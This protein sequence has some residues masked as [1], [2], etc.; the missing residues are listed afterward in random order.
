MNKVYRHRPAANDEYLGW[1][2]EEG[3][4]YETRLGPDKYIG[5]VE[6]GS[7]K[8]YEARLGPDKYIGRVNGKSGKIYLAKLGPDIYI[9]RVQTDG[10][11]FHHHNLAADEYL[12]KVIEMTSRIHGGAAFL[13]LIQPAYDEAAVK[14]DEPETGDA[15][16]GQATAPA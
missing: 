11:L 13:L 15:D 8:I 2:D 1:V 10:K 4:V 7:G 12:G 9:G 14:E 3:R 6:P 5:R 16:V